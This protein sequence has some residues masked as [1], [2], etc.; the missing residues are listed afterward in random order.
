[1]II[2]K[3]NLIRTKTRFVLNKRVFYLIIVVVLDHLV[4]KMWSEYT[5][6]PQLRYVKAGVEGEGGG[7]YICQHT[8]IVVKIHKISI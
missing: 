4:L 7:V 1:V 3:D 5:L 2:F 6:K 8:V